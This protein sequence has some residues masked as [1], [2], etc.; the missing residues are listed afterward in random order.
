MKSISIL[1]STLLLFTLAV[2]VRAQMASDNNG[3]V[4]CGLEARI[5]GVVF[6]DDCWDDSAA[7]VADIALTV[8]EPSQTFGLWLG[9]G[10]QGA[11]IIW[12]DNWGEVKSDVEALPFGVSLL[13]RAELAPGVAVRGEVGARYV[14]MDIDDW[15]DDYYYH[16]YHRRY[17]E[18][19]RYYHPD[20]YL[21]VDDTS[22]AVVALQLEFTHAPRYCFAIGGGYQFDLQSPDV[23][24]LDRP[25]GQVDLSGAFFYGSVGVVF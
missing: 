7:L 25:I 3:N 23:E 20:H 22:L 24:Y 11:S 8:W 14:S 12:E 6:D 2:P 9:L 19:D 1:L 17:S 18:R 15:D 21:D 10:G 16:H 13:A 5:G 4:H